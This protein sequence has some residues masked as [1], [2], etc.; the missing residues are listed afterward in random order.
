M[1]ERTRSF[2]EITLWGL[3]LAAIVFLSCFFF[4]S[5]DGGS[6]PSDDGLIK[7]QTD[8]VKISIPVVKDTVFARTDTIRYIDTVESVKT[9]YRVD[10]LIKVDTVEKTVSL[11]ITRKTYRDSTYMAIVSGYSPSLDYIETYN[12][13]VYRNVVKWKSPRFSVGIGG[14]Y[15]ITPK[16]LQPGIGITLQYNVLNIK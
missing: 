9:S 4:R 1:K 3:G 11:P 8:T 14:G 12:S 5:C 13:T 15:Y 16:G 2:I 7:V 10:T 6:K